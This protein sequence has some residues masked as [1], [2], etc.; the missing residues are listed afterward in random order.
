MA[1]VKIKMART[2]ETE[3]RARAQRSPSQHLNAYC[4][5]FHHPQT[6]E[7]A[8]VPITR[9]ME[10]RNVVYP[11]ESL[12]VIKKNECFQGNE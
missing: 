4:S 12:S 3:N 11:R 1:A 8:S 6:V 2:K 7:T 10:R 5:T 9:A